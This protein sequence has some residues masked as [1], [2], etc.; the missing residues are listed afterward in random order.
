M[1]ILNFVIIPKEIIVIIQFQKIRI[2]AQ[3]F[4]ISN[5]KDH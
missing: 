2:A 1:L 3:P 4:Y 5:S